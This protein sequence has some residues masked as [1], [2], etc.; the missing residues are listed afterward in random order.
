MPWKIIPI[1]TRE[2]IN[3]TWDRRA[4]RLA[5]IG[6]RRLGR[7]QRR[8]PRSELILAHV[9]RGERIHADGTTVPVRS[10]QRRRRMGRAR[11]RHRPETP[12]DTGRPSSPRRSRPANQTTPIHRSGAPSFSRS[13]GIVPRSGATNGRHGIGRRA[14]RQSRKRLEPQRHRSRLPRVQM[15]VAQNGSA[16]WANVSITFS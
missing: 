8:D 10:L 5:R 11:H 3:K 7:R 9:F 1:G 14:S 4:S 15:S 2:W 12:E 13:R 6:S 16:R